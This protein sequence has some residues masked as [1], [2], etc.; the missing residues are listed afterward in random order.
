ML[1]WKLR[2]VGGRLRFISHMFCHTYMMI[3]Y[4]GMF[5]CGLVSFWCRILKIM[6]LPFTGVELF[7][8][9]VQNLCLIVNNLART[10]IRCANP[11][12]LDVLYIT[13]CFCKL[14]KTLIMGHPLEIMFYSFIY[15]FISCQKHW[16]R[17]TPLKHC[18]R[19]S[20]LFL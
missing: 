4:K 5:V 11:L 9:F 20:F 14:S 10:L 16:S 2:M 13:L 12:K 7:F 17:A 18:S 6:F 1:K 19:H 8:V 15:V 3:E